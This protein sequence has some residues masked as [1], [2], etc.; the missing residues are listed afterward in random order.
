MNSRELRFDTYYRYQELTEGLQELAASRPDLLTLESVGESHEGRP[1][2]LVILT[3]KSTG[4]HKDKP[5]LWVDGNIHATEVSASSACLYVIQNLIDREA[6]DPRV[7][8]LLD[9]RTVY[10][11]PRVNPDGAELALAD[12]P[13]FLR[14]SVREYPFSEEAIEGLTTEDINGDGMILSMRL[15]DPNGPWKVSDQD[16]RLLVRRE[17]WDL[18]GPFYRVLP[19]GRYLGDWDGSTLNLAA[20]NRQLDLNRNFPAFWTTEG[21]Q[22][23]AGPYPTSEPEVAALVKFITEHPNICHGISFHTYSGVLLRAYSTDPDEA[24]PSEDLWAYQHLGEMGEKLTGYPAISTFE[25][26]RYHPKKV[27]RGNFVDWM[28]QHLGLFG[29]V[30]E[31]WSPHREAGL[32]EG[33]DLRTKSGDFRFIDWYREHDEA[34]DLALLKWSDEALHGKGYYDWTPFEHPQ[35]GSVEIGGWNE[36]LSFRNPPHHLLERELSRFPDWIVYQGLTSPKLAIRSN[37][38]EPLGANHYRLEVVV[39]NQG[40]LPTYIT[41]KALEIR[42]CRPIVAELEL[43]EGVKIVSGKV[44]QELGQLEGM[45]HKGSSPEPWQADESK[46]RIKLVWVVEGPAGSGLELTVKHQRAGVV[47]KT[48]RLTS[49]WP[50]SCKQKTPPM[51]EDFALVEAYHREIK[52]DPQRALAHARQVKEAW[53][54]QGMDTL[55]WSGWPLRPLFVPRKRLEFFSRAVHR[56]L[57]ELCREVLRR[58]DDPDELSRHIPLHPAMYETFITREGLEAENFLSLIRPDGFLYQDHWVWTEINGGNGSQVSNIYQEL[59]YPLFHSSPLFQKLGLDAAEGIGRPFQRYLDLVGEHIPEGADSPLIGILIHSKAWGVFET[60][61]DRVIK[62]IHYSQKLMEERGWR[63]E[64]VHEDQVVVEDG[65][66]RLKADGRPISV[67]C[68]YTI[69]TNFLSELERAHE[70]WPHWRGGKAGNTPILQPLAGMVLDKGA[71]P[72]MQEWLSWPIQDEDGFEVRLPSTVFPNEEMAK[73]YRRHKDEFV[74]KRSFVDKDTLVGRSVRPRH[75]NRVLKQ[76]MEG[77]D[78]VLQ[79]YRTLPE[80]I[81][82]VSTDGESIDWVP[83]QVEISPFIIKGEYAGGFAR[84]APSRESGVVLSPPPDDMGFTSVYQV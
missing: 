23:G 45:A 42:C 49:L 48:F 51:L 15:E 41:W 28:Y 50:G 47:K 40:W 22:P 67:I 55:E 8:H 16:P 5:A 46:D 53:Q 32:T 17:A 52:R 60:W 31:I 35:L 37:S 71:L 82:P 75:W 29:W 44:R 74:L 56:Q 61:P 65:V 79:D 66:C 83:V 7:S 27:I 84:Y 19:E 1:L 81:M 10:V 39:E 24:F 72:A 34:D 4:D 26:F 11:M 63:A 77:W 12:S 21:E 30:V 80:T 64:I 9:T 6:T 38:L 76:A 18:D 62:L 73:H 68:L 14:S 58:I 69:G 54:K 33:F 36:F 20:R 2:W 57:G 59:L 25:D 3:R 70:E 43:P 78:Y 13:S